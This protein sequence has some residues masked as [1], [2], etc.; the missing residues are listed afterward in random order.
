MVIG[1]PNLFIGDGLYLGNK[2]A[3]MLNLLCELKSE[4]IF[5]SLCSWYV[6]RFQRG[7]SLDTPIKSFVRTTADPHGW[8]SEHCGL[9]TQ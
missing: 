5:G 1:M 9:K 6:H 2:M 4:N 3:K 8:K 7:T